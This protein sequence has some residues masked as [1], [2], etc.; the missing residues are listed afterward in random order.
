MEKFSF[1]QQCALNW[2]HGELESFHNHYAGNTLDR[3]FYIQGM[4]GLIGYLQRII[5][6][7]GIGY[8]PRID[9]APQKEMGSGAK[10]Q[11]TNKV[12]A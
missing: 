5:S 6:E 7:N 11:A 12:T 4:S 1:T 8:P 10:Q 9:R 3:A 2:V